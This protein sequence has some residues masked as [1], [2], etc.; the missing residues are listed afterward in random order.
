MI[1]ISI[2]IPIYNVSS[3]I[4]R[5]VESI[6][7]Q[8]RDDF[9]IECI[10]VNDDTP[11]DSM[12]IVH[13]MVDN[14]NGNCHFVFCNHET[15][16][17][18]S[19]A[20]NTG[21]LAATGDY[22]IFIDS[23]D[24]FTADCLEKMTKAISKYPQVDMVLGN[25]FYCKYGGLFFPPVEEIT[26]YSDN[27]KMLCDSFAGV[28][29]TFAWNMLIRRDFL[30]RNNFLFVNNL[31][32]EDMPWCYRLYSELGS[33]AVLPD[34]TYIYEDNT[35]SIT[36]TTGEKIDDIVRSFC[37]IIDYI[38]DNIYEKVWVDSMIYC[39]SILL[40][41]MDK[42]SKYSCSKLIQADLER[43][44]RQLLYKAL[45][46]L[47]LFMALLFLTAYKPFSYVYKFS[48]IRK[49]YDR[50]TKIISVIENYI[51]KVRFSFNHSLSF[52][53]IKHG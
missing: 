40:R 11:D 3:Y 25:A 18:L 17:G 50:M 53:G 41:T 10:F 38:Q 47:H 13:D 45:Q 32:N 6:L 34:V 2:V 1:S 19:A 4:R 26:V 31:L 21:L 49:K 23:D 48:L 35:G 27:S 44:K 28:L 51:D 39:Y 37:G 42:A 33:M 24:H 9:D 43:I 29:P 30:L 15:N 14:Y 5:C 16:K 36:N 20:R 8:Q 22:I 12:G 52:G 7:I 46:S